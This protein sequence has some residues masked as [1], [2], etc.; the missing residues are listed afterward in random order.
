[1]IAVDREDQAHQPLSHQQDL[2]SSGLARIRVS[3]PQCNFCSQPLQDSIA[4]TLGSQPKPI[5]QICV[6][7]FVHITCHCLG[8][9][10]VLSPNSHI[11][12][13]VQIPKKISNRLSCCHHTIQN[14][15]QLSK[16]LGFIA[17]CAVIQTPLEPSR[18]LKLHN[19]ITDKVC[20]EN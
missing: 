19:L 18:L 5:S 10:S 7:H 9:W 17:I 11:H 6:R 20:C 16:T 1:M 8:C 12:W 14:L 15:P 3:T 4:T 2:V 13:K